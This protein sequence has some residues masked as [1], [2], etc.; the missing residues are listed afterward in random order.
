MKLT[1]VR[2]LNSRIKW[3]M[4][5]GEGNGQRTE[6]RGHSQET[7]QKHNEQVLNKI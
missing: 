7:G 1:Q 6:C 2:D 3:K 4:C 5:K